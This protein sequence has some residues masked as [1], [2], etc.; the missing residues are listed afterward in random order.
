[1]LFLILTSKTYIIL[2]CFKIIAIIHWKYMMTYI[3]EYFH[4]GTSILRASIEDSN[5][6][7][8]T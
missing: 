7:N 8:Y 2:N 6:I 3:L 4:N 5:G 1:M